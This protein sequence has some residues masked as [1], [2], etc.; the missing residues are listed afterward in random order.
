LTGNTSEASKLAGELAK[1]QGL[2][3]QLAAYLADFPKASNPFSAWA[4]YLDMIEAQAR[5]IAGM[6]PVAPTSIAGN[7]TSGT[8]SPAVQQMITSGQTVS[9]RADAAGNVNVYVSG[10]VVSEADLV[11]AVRAGLLSNSLS[12]SPSAIGRLKGSFAG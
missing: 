12:G 5:R 3:T 11:E 7:N 8:F 2:S 9:A 1:A 4:S 6:T 10:S